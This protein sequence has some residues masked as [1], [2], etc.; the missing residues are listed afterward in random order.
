[1][2]RTFNSLSVTKGLLSNG[3]KCTVKRFTVGDENGTFV[4]LTVGGKTYGTDLSITW[5]NGDFICDQRGVFPTFLSVNN[6]PEIN[7]TALCGIKIGHSY[8]LNALQAY[9]ACDRAIKLNI[10]DLPD[11][12]ENTIVYQVNKKGVILWSHFPLNKSHKAVDW[13]QI[14]ELENAAFFW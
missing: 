4:I 2:N 14:P 7:F 1:M 5:P 13:V 6:Y 12:L 11:S 10:K 3:E 8:E 9:N